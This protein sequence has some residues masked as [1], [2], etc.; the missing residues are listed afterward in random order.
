MTENETRKTPAEW[1]AERGSRILDPDG[2]RMDGAPPFD[3]PTTYADFSWRFAI[4]TIGPLNW[5]KEKTP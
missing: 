2:W 5:G 3:E 4:S 1:A